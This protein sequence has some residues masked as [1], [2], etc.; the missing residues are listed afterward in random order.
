MRSGVVAEQRW[1]A[2]DTRS[3]G[4]DANLADAGEQLRR[5]GGGDRRCRI[6]TGAACCAREL[7]VRRDVLALAEERLVQGV[8]EVPQSAL[9]FGPQAGS[10][11]Q[12]A[13]VDVL[14]PVDPQVASARLEQRPRRRPE[15]ER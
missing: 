10:E 13:P 6:E 2:A 11:R 4:F 8:L 5:V 1:D 15:L 12:C 14:R 3:L 7:R 9:T